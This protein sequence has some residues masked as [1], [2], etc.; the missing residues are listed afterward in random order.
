ME[1]GGTRGCDETTSETLEDTEMQE[2]I[3]IIFFFTKR[4]ELP[5][6]LEKHLFSC[7]L[8]IAQSHFSGPVSLFVPM[9]TILYSHCVYSVLSLF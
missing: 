4:P 7:K 5:E 1:R 8:L 2:I 3:I 9:K 6:T